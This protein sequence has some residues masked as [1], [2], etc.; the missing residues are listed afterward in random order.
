MD[1][2]TRKNIR[3]QG[4]D[5]SQNGAYFITVCVK[6]RHHLLWEN[7]DTTCRGELCSSE[8]RNRP[9]NSPDYQTFLT[10]DERSSPLQS[11]GN[12]GNE[13]RLDEPPKLSKIGK[14]ISNEIKKI[15]EIYEHVKI[16]KYVIMPNHIHMIILIDGFV[17]TDE[18]ITADEWT[19][20]DERSSPLQ[21]TCKIP[22]V[23]ANIVRP[24]IQIRPHNTN[25][26]Y[27]ENAPTVSRIIKQFKGSISKQIGY[28]IWQKLFH[29]H[30]IRDD[31]EYNNIWQY[32]DE[33]PIKWQN[34][35]YYDEIDQMRTN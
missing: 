21:E 24:G 18:R 34:D 19:N 23:G 33:N 27:P 16:D 25:I 32:I 17:K 11:T 15:P 30:I 1:L 35:C 12:P 10:A 8:T 3:L 28:S 6:D 7:G 20:A 29:D 2:Q 14:I 26:V 4:Y 5:Y 22:A 13:E 9:C 31:E